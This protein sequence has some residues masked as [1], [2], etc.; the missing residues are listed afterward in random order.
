MNFNPI[1]HLTLKC[2][3]FFLWIYISN[4]KIFRKKI[5]F[6]KPQPLRFSSSCT[7]SLY[8]SLTLSANLSWL[9]KVIIRLWRTRSCPGTGPCCR[10]YHLHKWHKFEF[11]GKFTQNLGYRCSL[12]LTILGM[13]HITE[14]YVD[15]DSILSKFEK[16]KFFLYIKMQRCAPFRTWR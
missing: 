12:D 8:V 14:E 11:L 13:W 1:K 6:N 10:P 16:L 3:V 2:C 15:G 9:E 7:C 4:C 5:S